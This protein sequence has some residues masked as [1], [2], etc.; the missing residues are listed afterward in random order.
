VAPPGTSP[1]S[2]NRIG[3]KAFGA[4]RSSAALSAGG[5]ND[6]LAVIPI[7]GSFAPSGRAVPY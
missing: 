7:P 4:D 1:W 2:S 5:T 6:L 3:S